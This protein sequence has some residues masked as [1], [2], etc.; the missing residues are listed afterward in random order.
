MNCLWCDQDIIVEINWDNLIVL[1]KPEQLCKKCMQSLQMLHGNQ[2]LKCSRVSEQKLCQDCERWSDS[3]IKDPLETNVSVFAY[4]EQMQ[5]M[6]TKWKYRGDYIVAEAFKQTFIDKYEESFSNELKHSILIPIP[7]SE[8]RLQERGFN[9]AKMLVDFLPGESLEIITRIH[10]E[11]QSKKT[12]SERISSDNPFI[13]NETINKTVILV[14]DI[15]T[16]GTT[17]RHA[18]TLLRENGCPKVYAYTLIRG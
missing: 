18:A 11:K 16:T 13:I 7:L 17:L 12:R 2:C 1:S 6:I 4:N 14:D 15:Y 8:E 10:S 3:L 9:Q 5:E